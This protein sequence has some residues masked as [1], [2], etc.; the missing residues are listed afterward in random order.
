M[1]VYSYARRRVAWVVVA[2]MVGL[3]PW[4]SRVVQAEEIAAWQNALRP[5]SRQTSPP[6]TL[7]S[8]GASAYAILIP[9]SPTSFELK[10][11]TDLSR[12]LKALTGA[13][14]QVAP[15]NQPPAGVSRFISVGATTL[16]KQS[17]SGAAVDL[18]DE[19][20]EIA[21]AGDNLLLRGG[22]TR[23][24]A[25]AVYALLEEDIGCR[26]YTRSS[27]VVLPT[28]SLTTLTVIPRSYVP[29]L[30]LRDPHY[31][32]AFDAEWSYRN[33]TNAPNAAVP[34]DAGGRV[35]YAAYFVHT[36]AMLLDQ[37]EIAKH[38]E[39]FAQDAGGKRYAAQLCPTNPDVARIVTENALKFLKE[40]PHSEIISISK[41]DNAGD[42]ICHCPTCTKLRKDEG[43]TDAAN[44]LV[45]V[46]KV[47]EAIEGKRP[48]VIVDTL[49]YLET[50]KVPTTMRPRRNVAIRFCNDAGGAWSY[51]FRPARELPTAELAKSWSAVSDRTYVWDY[52]VNFSHYLAPMP[53]FDVVAD[54][55]RFWVENKAEGVLLQGAYQGPGERDEMRAWV[56]AKLMWDPSRDVDALSRDFIRGHYGKAAGPIEAYDHLLNGLRKEHKAHMDGAIGIRYGMSEPFLSKAFLDR[57]TELFAQAAKL[58]AGDEKLLHAVERAEL[59]ILYA[60]L[61][62]G[63]QLVGESY[64]RCVDRF[65]QIAKREKLTYLAEGGADFEPKLAAFRQQ[66]PKPAS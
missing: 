38:P 62:Q 63:P 4:G 53:N 10:A 35:D 41:N 3:A 15:E 50:S 39:Y 28:S 37:G 19:G 5:T 46:N 24:I 7:V 9:A 27:D 34:E 49:A 22:R 6:L 8:G 48:D 45:L 33:R 25:N 55:I 18:G 20:Y 21:V 54:N 47:A 64:G 60:K 30:K 2:V 52:S 57:A 23:G 43:G 44:Q 32:A 40:S 36:H 17:S 31:H 66:V 29:K 59:P 1:I 26:W 11:A 58:A 14:F 13:A 42:Q 61:S 12:W 65:E 51:P 56:F 16:L